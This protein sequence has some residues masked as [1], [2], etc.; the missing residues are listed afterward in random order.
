MILILEL[1]FTQTDAINKTIPLL[2]FL[3][4]NEDRLEVRVM[5]GLC[6]SQSSFSVL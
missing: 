6:H 3:K 2:F 5:I 4:F 1:G